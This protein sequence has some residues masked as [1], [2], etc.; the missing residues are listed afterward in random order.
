MQSKAETIILICSLIFVFLIVYTPH[1]YY[2]YPLHID[3]WEHIARSNY[4]NEN[5]PQ[6]IKN[7]LNTQDDKSNLSLNLIPNPE[8]REKRQENE[9]LPKDW[10]I[11]TLDNKG[12]GLNN[13]YNFSSDDDFI[14]NK[15]NITLINKENYSYISWY[16][17]NELFTN[18]IR[19][20][21][22]DITKGYYK[23]D[24]VYKKND[25]FSGGIYLEFDIKTE[26]ETPPQNV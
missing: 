12:N 16:L 9:Q 21:T 19:T 11:L 25:E 14:L 24:L 6:D 10:N 13:Y 8:F 2:K 22:F 3:E 18:T 1:Y 15:Y 20:K 7:S 5:L 4:I 23:F 17:D 26:N